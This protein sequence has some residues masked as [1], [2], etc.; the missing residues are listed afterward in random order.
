MKVRFWNTP[1][2]K[3]QSIGSVSAMV[4]AIKANGDVV[5]SFGP[6]DTIIAGYALL[7]GGRESIKATLTNNGSFKSTVGT[8]EALMARF[9][10]GA[11]GKTYTVVML[12]ST[13]GAGLFGSGWTPMSFNR[14]YQ[15]G[16]GQVV[17]VRRHGNIIGHH[18]VMDQ[19]GSTVTYA[20]LA[21]AVMGGSGAIMAHTVD[22][23]D[24]MFS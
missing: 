9:S 24:E 16:A 11:F 14:Q 8:I 20:E 22:L 1:A 6:G 4:K 15:Y 7:M 2:L 21:Q 13:K 18:Q 17:P 23:L 10:T 3:D 12:S 5:S 19:T